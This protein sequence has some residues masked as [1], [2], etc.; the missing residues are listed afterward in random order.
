MAIKYPWLGGTH[1]GKKGGRI[2]VDSW[3]F[4]TRNNGETRGMTA[5][6]NRFMLYHPTITD[7]TG[8]SSLKQTLAKTAQRLVSFLSFLFNYFILWDRLSLCS[9]D[10]P[11]THYIDQAGLISTCLCLASAG[12]TGMQPINPEVISNIFLSFIYFIYMSTL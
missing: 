9:S 2:W 8:P 1:P 12:I 3:Y 5:T 4:I 10:C 6:P 7:K 11:G